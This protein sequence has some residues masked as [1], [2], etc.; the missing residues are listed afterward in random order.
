M[1]QQRL[2]IVEL[3]HINISLKSHVG[4]S[5]GA[6]LLGKLLVPG[7]PI[8]LDWLVGWLFWV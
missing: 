1:L 6:M 3:K 8:H 5:G 7:R 2:Y 4:W